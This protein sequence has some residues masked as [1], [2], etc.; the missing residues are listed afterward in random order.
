MAGVGTG[1][2]SWELVDAGENSLSARQ[3]NSPEESTN[4][5]DWELTLV[6]PLD[7]PF[8]LRATSNGKLANEAAI[9]LA[10]VPEASSQTGTIRIVCTDASPFE[11]ATK[12]VQPLATSRAADFDIQTLRGTYRYIP[13]QDAAIQIR[14]SSGAHSPLPAW[15]WFTHLSSRVTGGGDVRHE[16]RMFLETKGLSSLS[17]ELPE[18]AES[19]NV[20]VDGVHIDADTR[21]AP[22]RLIILLP[23]GHRFPTV[24]VTYIT[25]QPPFTFASWVSSAW[26]TTNLTPLQRQWDLWTPPAM[27]VA[28]PT[29][30]SHTWDERLFGLQLI[31]R[32]DNE[33]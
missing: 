26:P 7:M 14:R 3:L 18:G 33:L 24:S 29:E 31:R 28:N 1:V 15:I 16:A 17:L 11:I 8:R 2:P 6:R 13:S 32:R 25:A 4:S 22:G 12:N 9:A 23:K 20:S 30:S 10:S 5:Q 21:D 19:W 27:Q